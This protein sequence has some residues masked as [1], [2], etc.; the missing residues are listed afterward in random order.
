MEP[1]SFRN[2][3][4]LVGRELQMGRVDGEVYESPVRLPGHSVSSGVVPDRFRAGRESLSVFQNV[5]KRNR[6]NKAQNVI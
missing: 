5:I 1:P 6:G 3:G 2:D 4:Y